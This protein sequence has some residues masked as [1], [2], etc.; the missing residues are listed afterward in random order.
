MYSFQVFGA[1]RVGH[2][3]IGLTGMAVM[4][5]RAE[6]RMRLT[7]ETN[8]DGVPVP[9][10]RV[11]FTEEDQA[12]QRK[13]MRV[14]EEL[15]QEFRPIEEINRYSDTSS[16]HYAGTCRMGTD[17]KTSMCDATG[18]LHEIPRIHVA[19]ASVFVNSPEKNPT[20]TLMALAWR[21]AEHLARK[22]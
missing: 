1:R 22:L 6:N 16:I 8:G 2:T 9:E 4:E 5:P 18:A 13:M 10:F 3:V 7:G 11:G 20:L 19:D 12:R 21:S 14:A 15:A 17:P